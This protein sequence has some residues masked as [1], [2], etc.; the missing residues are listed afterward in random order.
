MHGYDPSGDFGREHGS[1]GLLARNLRVLQ[2]RELDE[3]EEG[4]YEDIMPKK[5]HQ[6]TQA[7]L[8]ACRKDFSDVKFAA[9][10]KNMPP[11]WLNES[12]IG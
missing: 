7:E 3:V 1:D 12:R 8:A 9:L 4:D 5:Q 6:P 10:N 11:E 2:V